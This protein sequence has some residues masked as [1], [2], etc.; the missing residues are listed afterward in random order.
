MLLEG[1]TFIDFIKIEQFIHN[2]KEYSYS[3]DVTN[4]TLKK[5]GMI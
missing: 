3:I 5:Y 4:N 2:Y 1:H